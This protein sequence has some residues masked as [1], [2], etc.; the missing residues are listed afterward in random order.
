[1]WFT[2]DNQGL[3]TIY[4]RKPVGSQFEQMV[5]KTP[6]GISERDLA[7]SIYKNIRSERL[8]L[9]WVTAYEV[10]NWLKSKW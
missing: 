9:S 7:C 10:R 4:I 6:N 5:S 1:M 8:E 2:L 3:F